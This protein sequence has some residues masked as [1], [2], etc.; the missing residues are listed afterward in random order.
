MTLT[1]EIADFGGLVGLLLALATLLTANRAAALQKLED[2]NDFSEGDKWLEFVLDATLAVLTGLVFL[3]GLPLAV[4]AARD[5]HPLAHGG[6]LR[7]VFV[8][9]WVLLLALIAWQLR[10]AK[11]AAGL[12][13]P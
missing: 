8:L 2:A 1:D 4:R 3:A 10:L 13:V 9:A 11:A 5:L 12:T 6:P 7:G